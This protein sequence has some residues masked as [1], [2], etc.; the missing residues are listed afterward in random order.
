MGFQSLPSYAR[1]DLLTPGAYTRLL[2]NARALEAG[3]LAEHT[4]EGEHAMPHFC[5][6]VG[7]VNVAAGPVYSL[8]GFDGDA[9]LDT[10]YNP[11]VGRRG[12]R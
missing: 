10:G 3:L 8:V 9:T 7:T 12:S 6:S 2:L 11:T 4:A 1:K 5:R